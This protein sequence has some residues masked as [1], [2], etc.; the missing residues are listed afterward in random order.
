MTLALSTTNRD[1]ASSLV[2]LVDDCDH[3]DR[4]TDDACGEGEAHGALEGLGERGE[5]LIV[6][7]RVDKQLLRKPVDLVGHTP[8]RYGPLAP[9]REPKRSPKPIGLR[10]ASA[11]SL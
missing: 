4:Y 11:G 2:T 8:A 3:L 6:A 9:R 5:L 7:V 1:Q 10:D